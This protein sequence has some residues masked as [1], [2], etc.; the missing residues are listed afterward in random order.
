MLAPHAVDKAVTISSLIASLCFTFAEPVDD[1]FLF[2]KSSCA[3]VSGNTNKS[4]RPKERRIDRPIDQASEFALAHLT[5]I[6]QKC[7]IAVKMC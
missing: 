5:P 7:K 2:V 1:I 3:L 4:L 6:L